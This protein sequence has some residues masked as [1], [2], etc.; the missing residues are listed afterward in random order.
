MI[1]I[2]LGWLAESI[3][4]RFS[5]LTRRIGAAGFFAGVIA[6][7]PAGHWYLTT[8]DWPYDKLANPV[9]VFAHSWLTSSEKPTL[10][11]MKTTVGDEDFHPPTKVTP[12][13]MPAARPAIRHVVLWVYESVPWEYVGAYG[14][15]YGVTPNLDRWAKHGA[16]FENVYAHAPA[17]NKTLFSL[18]CSTYPWISFKAETEE[19]PDVDLPSIT[20]ELK[21]RGFVSGFFYSG[22]LAFQ[23]SGAFVKA[24]G[25]DLAQDYKQRK[26]SRKLFTNDQWPF[27]NGSDDLSTTESLIAWFDQQRATNKTFSLLW[28]NMTHYPYFTEADTHDFGPK[29]NLFNHYLNALYFGDRAFGVLM[30][31]LEKHKLLDETLVVV[32]GD[33]GEAFMRHFQLSHGNRIYE[34][35]CHVP[36]IVINPALFAGQRYKAVG[37][38]VDVA[39]TISDILGHPPAAAW[40][41]RSL[42]AADRPK[43]TYF[44]APWSDHL[45]GFREADFKFIYNATKDQY[46]LY[47][48]K[49]DPTEQNNFAQ[50]HKQDIQAC[51]DILAAWVQYQNRMFERLI[52][53][54]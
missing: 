6:F 39:P 20:S 33:H 10:F 24:R 53:G 44:F 32:V 38:I 13:T 7:I 18:L 22:D 31:H 52:P 30:E 41:G 25:F 23:G 54:K 2:G 12:S 14:S 19:K 43:R 15:K 16:I 26:S 11:T 42:F 21:S 36:M 35:N 34:E 17:T 45:F 40:Q 29:E 1:A 28:T 8:R 4:R 9:Y 3:S 37:G 27:L 5:P 50:S 48:L 47:D 49:S 46:E 51:V